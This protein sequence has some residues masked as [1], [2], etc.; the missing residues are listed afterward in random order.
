MDGWQVDERVKR[1]FAWWCSAAKLPNSQLTIK[2]SIVRMTHLLYFNGNKHSIT[3]FGSNILRKYKEQKRQQ[4]SMRK[5]GYGNVSM[6][7]TTAT[8]LKHRGHHNSITITTNTQNTQRS[9]GASTA[10]AATPEPVSTQDTENNPFAANFS[11]AR[12]SSDL[13]SVL[14][15]PFFFVCVVL[16]CTNFVGVIDI[17]HPIS[18]A[19]STPSLTTPT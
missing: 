1:N 16:F 5:Y 7:T 15:H 4:I 10:P 8:N 3:T 11:H 14:V 13:A 18:V 2:I 17:T 6:G 9:T 19:T 12:I